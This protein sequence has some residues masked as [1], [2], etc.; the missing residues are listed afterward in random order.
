MIE[1]TDRGAQ[2]TQIMILYTGID[3]ITN[4]IS[5]TNDVE[6]RTS[7]VQNIIIY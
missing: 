1:Q 2:S 5:I 4:I 7:F 6:K 3:S